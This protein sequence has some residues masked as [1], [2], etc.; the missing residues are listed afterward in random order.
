MQNKSFHVISQVS[1]DKTRYQETIRTHSSLCSYYVYGYISL[2]KSCQ[3]PCFGDDSFEILNFSLFSLCINHVWQS[4]ICRSSF[5][6]LNSTLTSYSEGLVKFLFSI[7]ANCSP[8][9]LQQWRYEKDSLNFFI[10]FA[11]S[12]HLLQFRFPAFMWRS[13]NQGREF[14]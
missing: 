9:K 10:C 1:G 5:F 14:D 13:P 4:D 3:L 2:R 11:F 7:E 8:K 12:W 6:S